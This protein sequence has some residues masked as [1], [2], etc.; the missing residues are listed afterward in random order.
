[1]PKLRMVHNLIHKI[2]LR[3]RFDWPHLIR[4]FNSLI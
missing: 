4:S 3:F 1:V 2:K